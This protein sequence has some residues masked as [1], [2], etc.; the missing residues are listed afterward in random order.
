MKSMIDR[1]VPAAILAACALAAQAQTAP[2]AAAPAPH[3]MHMHDPARMHERLQEHHARRMERLKRILQITPQQEGAWS[4]WTS[5]MKP[6]PRARP[7]RDELTRMTTPQRID[8]LKQLRAQRMAEQDRRGDATK[9]FYAQLSGPQ[10]KAFD[11]ISL[12]F[13]GGGKRGADMHHR[14]RG[15]WH[16]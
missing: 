3:G 15:R 7:D 11:E 6:A 5:A 14:E 4:A 1:L 8:T 13:L 2:P 16:S 9:T 12:K 10:Q